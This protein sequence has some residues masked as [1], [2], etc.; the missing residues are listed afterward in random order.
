MDRKS[1]REDTNV[2]EG[3]I[4]SSLRFVGGAKENGLFHLIILMK[5]LVSSVFQMEQLLMIMQFI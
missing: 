5:I 2:K 1:S 4:N 3:E